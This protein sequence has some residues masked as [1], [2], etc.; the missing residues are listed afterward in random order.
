MKEFGLFIKKWFWLIL[1]IS[2]LF[3]PMWSVWGFLLVAALC[4]FIIINVLW[5]FVLIGL[6][7]GGVARIFGL[8]D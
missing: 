3:P 5:L 1:L 6:L 2:L 4:L 7:I 8:A